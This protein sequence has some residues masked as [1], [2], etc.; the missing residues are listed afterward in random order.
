MPEKLL[1]KLLN[2]FERL[3]YMIRGIRINADLLRT[4]VEVLNAAEGKILPQN[5][6][7]DI[8]ERTPD[9]LDRRVKIALQSDLRTA[10]IV[11]DE[12][13]ERGVV[14]VTTIENPATGRQIKATRLL[15]AWT[16]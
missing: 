5:C 16:W 12:L 8:A 6:R 1:N 13:A 9:G 2:L 15:K 10:D 14:E 11:S 3:P 7:S 4:T